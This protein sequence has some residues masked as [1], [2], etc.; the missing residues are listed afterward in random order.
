[1]SPEPDRQAT[2]EQARAKTVEMVE[3]SLR[4]AERQ[5]KILFPGDHALPEVAEKIVN[6]LS[7]F[8]LLQ[9]LS[10]LANFG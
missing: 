4:D 5:G 9:V 3:L 2:I 8:T 10:G 6:D 7:S 1:M